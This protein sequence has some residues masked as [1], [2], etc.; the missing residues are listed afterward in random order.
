MARITQACAI[1]G[2][3]DSEGKTHVID[4]INEIINPIEPIEPIIT[5]ITGITQSMVDSAIGFGD[6][7]KDGQVFAE[8]LIEFFER[9]DFICAY[10]GIGYD[11]PLLKAEMKRAGYEKFEINIPIIDPLIFRRRYKKKMSKNKLIDAA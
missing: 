11:I 4:V 1:L 3:V 8:T 10:N 7:Y 5:Q 9:A 6:F 2:R